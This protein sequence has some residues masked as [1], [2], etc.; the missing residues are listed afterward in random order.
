MLHHTRRMPASWTIGVLPAVCL[1][2]VPA[3]AAVAAPESAQVLSVSGTPDSLPR[4]YAPPLLSNGGLSMLIDY[5]G[6]QFQ[7]AYAG[8]T[9]AIWWA[10]RR[11]GPPKD[12]LV[13][14]GHFEQEISCSGKT[15]KNPSR[16]TQSLNTREALTTCQCDYGGSLSVETTVFIPLSQDIVAIRKRFLPKSPAARTARLELKYAFASPG[17]ANAPPKR[18]VITPKWNAATASL[19]VAYQIDAYHVYDGILSVLCDRPATPRIEKNTFSLAADVAM[20]PGSPTDVT[21]YLLF[22]DSFDGKD[23]RERAGRLKSLVK[24]QGFAGLLAD[25]RRLWGEYWGESSI[26]IPAERIQRAYHTAQY[27]LRANATRWSFP[28]AVLNTHWAGR[29]F[30]WDEAFCFLGLA[31]SNHLSISRR[32]PEFRYAGLRK[33]LDRTSHYFRATPSYGA[34]YPWETIE[35]GTEGLATPGFWIDH[36]FHMSNIALCSW[37]QYLYSGDRDYLKT[38]GYPVIK[39]CATFFVEQMI[40]EDSDGSLFFG[41]C[42]DLERLGPARRNPFMTSCG[43]IFTLEA[44]NKAA[45]V[46]GVDAELAAKWKTMAGKLTE[47]LPHDDKEY[48]PYAG[49]PERSI[50]VLGGVFP[51][52]VFDGRNVLQKN[53]VYSFVKNVGNYGNM[54]PVG[55]SVSAWY[56][57]WMAAALA[58]LGDKT[59]AVNR[60][61]QV[62]EGTGCFCEVFEINEEKVVMRPWFSTAAGNFVYAT[63]Q[64]LLQCRDDQILIAP[65][66]PDSW[67]DFCFTLPCYEDLRAAVSVK[68]GRLHALTLTPGNPKKPYRRT[69]IVPERLLSESAVRRSA[70]TAV[71]RQNG[72]LRL[73]LQFQGK[74]TLLEP[75]PQ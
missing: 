31:S 71:A 55:K 58:A 39:E 37:F 53:A 13:P 27:H 18:G 35:D 49:C 9:P 66:V 2:F 26:H 28:V 73:D 72:A 22:A 12:Q 51:Y 48:V 43:A 29:Y 20:Q 33:A 46:L 4:S 11:Y 63:N 34:R 16:W 3:A 7:R 41:K 61:S 10:G 32:E 23:Y 1:L 6:C 36:V 30:G 40:Y 38:T 50:A 45:G 74:I 56:G 54:Y 19:D 68:D 64:V 62:A 69:L 44:A 14:F 47:S 25:H 57:G 24:T 8:M 59:E 70:V 65:A 75:S 15:Y 21:F 52:P 42:T 17:A 60:L 67:K 5:Q